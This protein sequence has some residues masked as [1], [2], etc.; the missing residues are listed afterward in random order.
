M[1]AF[2]EAFGA[3]EEII[4]AANETFSKLEQWMQTQK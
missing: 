3:D 1:E 2:G 4:T